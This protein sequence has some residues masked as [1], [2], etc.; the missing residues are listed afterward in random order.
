MQAA[1]RGVDEAG[2]TTGGT[3]SGD[4]SA[5]GTDAAPAVPLAERA[6]RIRA[7]TTR[8]GAAEPVYDRGIGTRVPE[9]AS[10]YDNI[11]GAGTPSEHMAADPQQAADA[12]EATS[13][14]LSMKSNPHDSAAGGRA[15]PPL[16]N[17]AHSQSAPQRPPPQSATR[18]PAYDTIRF[19]LA[20]GPPANTT[21]VS[22]ERAA[23]R[24]GRPN[25]TM[26]RKQFNEGRARGEVPGQT[27]LELG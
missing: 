27:F 11:F 19:M 23:G 10:S 17:R 3:T 13:S 8:V 16:S 22:P 9:E 4:A 15:S 12:Q 21:D 6:R 7:T 20:A 14:L 18:E 25:L 5:T 2:Y 1:R 24:S 26:T